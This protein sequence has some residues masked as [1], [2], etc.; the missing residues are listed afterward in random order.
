MT[1]ASAPMR[2]QGR[3]AGMSDVGKGMSVGVGVKVG[4]GVDVDVGVSVG[5]G[6][7]VGVG[8]DVLVGMMMDVGTG[9]GV[10]VGISSRF[11][12]VGEAGK[13][14]VIA[15]GGAFSTS[16]TGA[17]PMAQSGVPCAH[18]APGRLMR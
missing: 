1:S 8:V 12:G 14:A 2:S 9:E 3:P 6:V 11:D 17:P 18:L 10:G 15:L 5:K 13:G 4:S 16:I 7:L